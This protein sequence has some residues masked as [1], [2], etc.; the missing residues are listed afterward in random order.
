V[1]WELDLFPSSDTREERFIVCISLVLPYLQ[2]NLVIQA[3]Q[4][5]IIGNVHSKTGT[6]GKDNC[7]NM[8]LMEVTM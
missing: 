2:G 5:C 3:D 1:F 4:V 6:D 8:C 7:P